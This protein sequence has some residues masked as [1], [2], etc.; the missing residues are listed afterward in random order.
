[1]SGRPAEDD[2]ELVAAESGDEALE[3]RGGRLELTGHRHQE[4]VAD[5]VPVAVVHRFEP[6]EVDEDDPHPVVGTEV[7]ER[8]EES[9]A[10]EHPGQD[11]LEGV[12]LAPP[13]RTP[14]CDHEQ[15]EQDH[16]RSDDG[17][18]HEQQQR[19]RVATLGGTVVERL[20][21]VGRLARAEAGDLP[22][23]TF[24]FVQHTADRERRAVA[25][26]RR[27]RAEHGRDE[28]GIDPAEQPG[29]P[30]FDGRRRGRRPH[31]MDQIELVERPVDGPEVVGTRRPTPQV[32]DQWVDQIGQTL[33]CAR[34]GHPSR[35]RASSQ[36]TEA[37]RPTQC[38]DR[39]PERRPRRRRIRQARGGCNGDVGRDPQ[40][41]EVLGGAI[42][43][44]IHT[45]QTVLARTLDETVLHRQ[46]L[47]SDRQ[48]G[49]ADRDRYDLHRDHVAKLLGGDPRLRRRRRYRHAPSH[50][51]HVH[52]PRVEHRL[53]AGRIDHVVTGGAEQVQVRQFRDPHR[54][55]ANGRQFD[56]L[57]LRQLG[58]AVGTG[59]ERTPHECRGRDGGE[60]QHR[61][62]T[63]PSRTTRRRDDLAP[64]TAATFGQPCRGDVGSMTSGQG[65]R[66]ME[67]WIT[68]PSDDGDLGLRILVG[69]CGAPRRTTAFR[70]TRPRWRRT[71]P[72]HR[73]PGRAPSSHRRS[74]AHQQCHEPASQPLRS[75]A[76]PTHRSGWSR[77]HRRSS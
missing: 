42:G 56:Q 40:H 34:T 69:G 32:L 47:G 24:G 38:S 58:V 52:L 36:D 13:L 20:R 11:V 37:A 60:E 10:V 7:H 59:A 46:E 9:T 33:R 54:L 29:E 15:Q 14:R 55:Q 63:D 61:E 77:A 62:Q 27:Q 72:H 17:R 12:E 57:A 41:V 30:R 31:T 23:Q 18:R 43:R 39:D 28:P 75:G 67:R 35:Q 25:A 45:G 71:A 5:R 1:M 2:R 51:G 16:R 22:D 70:R 21:P 26:G 73:R 50:L 19:R 4:E 44:R 74:G 48:H 65:P 6:V 49:I 66:P 68:F 8:R 76:C 53:E 64:T 3:R